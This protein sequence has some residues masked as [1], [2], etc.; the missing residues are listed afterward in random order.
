VTGYVCKGRWPHVAGSQRGF[1]ERGA[2]RDE[3]LAEEDEVLDGLIAGATG[4]DWG[5]GTRSFEEI[6]AEA[7]VSSEQLHYL[8]W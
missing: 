7:T 3:L 4:A 1:L 2:H 8:K 6:G 5:G